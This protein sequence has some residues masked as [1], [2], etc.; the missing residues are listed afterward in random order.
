MLLPD[1]GRSYLSKIFDDQWM[2]DFGFLRCG[3]G[4]CAGDVLAAKDRAIAD[5]VLITPDQPARD[6][7][8]LMRETRRVAARRVA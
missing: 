1:S 5:L 8:A 3:D 4:P 7:I 6:A 2:I